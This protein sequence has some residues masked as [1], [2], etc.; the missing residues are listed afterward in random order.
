MSHLSL[1]R[2]IGE[3][4]DIGDEIRVTVKRLKGLSVQLEIEAP[5]SVRVDR[6]EMRL[7][8]LAAERLAR[9]AEKVRQQ[10]VATTGAGVN[11][12]AARISDAMPV[13]HED[14][15]GERWDGQS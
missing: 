10:P 5:A 8:K 13:A 9:L 12:L 6:H 15:D 7:Q 2:R 3:T 1:T 14:E 4:I 11:A